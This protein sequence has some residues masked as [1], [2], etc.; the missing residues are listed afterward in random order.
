LLGRQRL[1]G[2]R[3]ESSWD[4]KLARPISTNKLGMLVGTFDPSYKGGI[5]RRTEVSAP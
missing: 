3:F 2:S 4:K 5:E 1:G